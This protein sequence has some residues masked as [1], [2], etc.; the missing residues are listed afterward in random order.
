MRTVV[1]IAGVVLVLVLLLAM[2]SEGLEER[3]TSHRRR[4]KSEKVKSVK[5]RAKP[6]APKYSSQGSR[7]GQRRSKAMISD[8]RAARAAWWATASISQR[9]EK[10]IAE[11]QAELMK[12]QAIDPSEPLAPESLAPVTELPI[13]P[14]IASFAITP[15]ILPTAVAS[16]VPALAVSQ[17]PVAEMPTAVPSVISMAPV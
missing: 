5:R 14:T 3:R 17:V 6:G 9:R 10:R 13:V 12:W 7:R 4:G 1:V 15:T 2:R 8:E 16:G 11:L